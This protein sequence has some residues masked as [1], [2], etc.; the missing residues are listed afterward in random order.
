MGLRVPGSDARL[1][2]DLAR[3]GANLLRHR[4]LYQLAADQHD[5]LSHETVK[6]S[7]T[8]LLDDVSNRHPSDP[9]AS[10]CPFLI[11]LSDHAL[12]V[13]TSPAGGGR[14]SLVRRGWPG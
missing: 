2:R 10:W 8:N 4:G 14:G 13:D 11:G 9:G 3:P 7:I 5:R 12:G 1:R 6:A